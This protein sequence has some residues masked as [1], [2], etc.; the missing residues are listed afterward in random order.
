MGMGSIAKEKLSLMMKE[1]WRTGKIQGGQKRGTSRSEIKWI[2]YICPECKTEFMDW[3][4]SKRKYCST[5]CANLHKMENYRG[6]NA[7]SR[8]PGVGE[9]IRQSKKG[10]RTVYGETHGN[11]RGGIS[12]AY[13]TGY[14]SVEY[15]Q[16]RQ[17]VFERDSYTC[18]ECGIKG[19]YLTAH[20]IKSF[21][22]YPDLRFDIDNGLTLC[23]NCHCKLDRYRARF[24]PIKEAVYA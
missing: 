5:K 13:K 16:W 8:R 17:R 9:K 1:L 2:T 14:Y 18:Q 6:D 20:H 22:K 23:E 24:K 11:W 4:I 15:K 12:R 3:A 19:T 7:T 21:A 10:I